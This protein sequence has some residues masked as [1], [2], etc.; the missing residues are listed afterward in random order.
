[1]ITFNEKNPNLDFRHK[2][3]LG[4]VLGYELNITKFTKEEQAEIRQQVASYRE[5]DELILKG[6]LFRLDG[7]GKKR[8]WFLRLVKGQKR[9]LF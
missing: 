3:A 5:N 7:L 2:V 4:G 9:V 6:D 8:I 1:M